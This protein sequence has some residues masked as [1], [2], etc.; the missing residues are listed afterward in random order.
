MI[1]TNT[2]V[3]ITKVLP[4]GTVT[5]YAALGATY[6]HLEIANGSSIKLFQ[7]PT[8]ITDSSLTTAGEITF[9]LVPVSDGVNRVKMY[10]SSAADLD[11]NVTLTQLGSV[12]VRK[13]A[14]TATFTM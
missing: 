7:A 2:T 9:T 4:A 8:T 1:T 3:T 12:S 13:V 10:V 14:S 5:T 6:F 11:G